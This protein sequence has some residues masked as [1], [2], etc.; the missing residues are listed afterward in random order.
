MEVDPIA[1]VHKAG[2][3][4]VLVD[5][6]TSRDSE[7]PVALEDRALALRV[8]ALAGWRPTGE[9]SSRPRDLDVAALWQA[10]V[11]AKRVVGCEH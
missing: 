9:R 6:A 1:L 3:L 11:A 2:E 8:A 5:P 7:V 10:I 4:Y